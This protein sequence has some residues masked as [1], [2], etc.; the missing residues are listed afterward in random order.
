M[1]MKKGE[2]RSWNIYKNKNTEDLAI[3]AISI[4]ISCNEY[5]KL[6][7]IKRIH[8]MSIRDVLVK[9]IETLTK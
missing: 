9:G 3:K 8:K 2:K 1:G 4:K 6:Q 5:E 7:E